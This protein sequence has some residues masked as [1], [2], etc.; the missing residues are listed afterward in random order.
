VKNTLE[1]RR[2]H[3]RQAEEAKAGGGHGLGNPGGSGV[4]RQVD[5]D[6]FS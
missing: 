2:A 6:P 3:L 4:P 1:Q 5:A